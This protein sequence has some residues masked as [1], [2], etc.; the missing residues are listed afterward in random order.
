MVGDAGFE[1]VAP[2]KNNDIPIDGSHNKTKK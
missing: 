2:E 1:P